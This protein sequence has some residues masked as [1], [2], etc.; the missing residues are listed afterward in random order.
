ARLTRGSD[1]LRA[2]LEDRAVELVGH[3]Q[4]REAVRRGVDG[5]AESREGVPARAAAAGRADEAVL[6]VLVLPHPLAPAREGVPAARPQP[7]EAGAGDP[8]GARP[9]SVL[10]SWA[11]L[12]RTLL[13]PAAPAEKHGPKA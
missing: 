6:A 11:V 12:A 1:P 10:L 2:G 7:V 3:P 5:P 8:V 9:G 4:G 13:A